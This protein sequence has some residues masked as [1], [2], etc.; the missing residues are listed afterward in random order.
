MIAE[1]KNTWLELNRM[2]LMHSIELTFDEIS[3][4]QKNDIK[5]KTYSPPESLGNR[6]DDIKKDLTGEAAIDRLSRIFK[7]SS[8]EKKVLLVCAGVQLN[9]EYGF[10]ISRIHNNENLV[11]PTFSLLLQSFND[12]HWD[13][14]SPGSSLRKWGLIEWE[15]ASV[16]INRPLKIDETILHYLTACGTFDEQLS[17]FIQPITSYYP[18]AESQIK[19]AQKIS[20]YIIKKEQNGNILELQ[21]NQ[22]DDFSG[23]ALQIAANLNS[24]IHLLKWNALPSQ[25]NDA[26]DIVRRWNRISLLNGYSLYIDGT[27]ID[28]FSAT[29]SLR[30]FIENCKT[31]I[32]IGSQAGLG[33]QFYNSTKFEIPEIG[34][35]EQQKLWEHALK[36]YEEKPSVIPLVNQFHLSA[37]SIAAISNY[38]ILEDKKEIDKKLWE[39]CCEETRPSFNNLAER[40]ETKATWDDIVLP[41]DVRDTL[42]EMV[43]HVRYKTK[44]YQD[45]GFA[46]KTSRGLGISALF[47]GESGTG[48]TMAAEVIA[49]ELK[50]DLY[51]IDLSQVVN[52][53]I[54][55]TEK[56]LKKIFDAAETGSAILLFDEADTLFGKRSEVRDSHDRYSNLQIGYLL[57]RME[58]FRGLSILTTNIKNAIDKAFE[59]R[60]RFIINFERPDQ[61]QRFKIWSRAFPNPNWVAG[62]DYQKLAQINIPGG[63]IQNIAMNAAFLAA[64]ENEKIDMHHLLKATRKE[65][66]KMD[67]RLS[68]G[69]LRHWDEA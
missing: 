69:E 55:E 10:L 62:V 13:A 24:K 42:K 7:L 35:N 57:Q 15:D 30:V 68:N 50:L 1:A 61:K 47:Y 44:V 21:G 63:S 6:I 20:N 9:S 46:I 49:N 26:L 67:K 60:I 59:R 31:L 2:Y 16:L 45:G 25:I 19:Q 11:H 3:Y 51:R 36:N 58:Q 29:T 39:I 53:Y 4:Y 14:I 41:E 38:T 56:N 33:T 65:Y 66:K 5:Q 28:D 8:F 32:F 27:K 17:F 23:I 48:K 37:R 22:T 18:L 43:L 52:K 64:S 54:G 40:I 12:A 34:I